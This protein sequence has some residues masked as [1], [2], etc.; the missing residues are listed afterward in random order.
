MTCDAL[1]T[2][3]SHSCD[4]QAASRKCR[5]RV[6]H[7]GGVF[8]SSVHKL[9]RHACM[10]IRRCDLGSSPRRV[11]RRPSLFPLTRACHRIWMNAG[12]GHLPRG[13]VAVSTQRAAATEAAAAAT[14]AAV[15]GQRQQQQQQQQ[16]VRVTAP[17]LS[18]L[19]CA[20]PMCAC[21]ALS[22][23]RSSARAAKWPVCNA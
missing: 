17:A 20:C 21:P 5:Y 16:P 10:S 13:P 12:P 18:S 19:S 14:L 8:S 23:S 4:A 11:D 2:F 7:F 15:A 3:C 6:H 1:L 9:H 22:A